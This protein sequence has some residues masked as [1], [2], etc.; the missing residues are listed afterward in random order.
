[1]E[2]S[3]SNSY[4][5]PDFQSSSN[6]KSLV[7]NEFAGW[8]KSPD[9]VIERRCAS[10]EAT[11]HIDLSV[12]PKKYQAKA[13]VQVLG[14]CYV[15]ICDLA[16]LVNNRQF[17]TERKA[18]K[19]LRD[20]TSPESNERFATAR[21]SSQGH[22]SKLTK[23]KHDESASYNVRN[24]SETRLIVKKKSLP[25]YEM[26]HCTPIRRELEYEESD[27]EPL[28]GPSHHYHNPNLISSVEPKF[29]FPRK[30]PSVQRK[31]LAIHSESEATRPLLNTCN[32]NSIGQVKNIG[33]QT[34][35]ELYIDFLERRISCCCCSSHSLPP[36]YLKYI[37][38]KPII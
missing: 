32:D 22:Y 12:L 4:Q 37:H 9:E 21:I 19:R 27:I 2:S 23:K 24:V 38:Y 6:I 17:I 34:E 13:K 26:P 36:K 25:E 7:T 1:M 8:A 14:N 18:V 35:T 30:N 5:R 31:P 28:P 29:P 10:S 20:D 3:V 15:K 33:T 11:I 16:S